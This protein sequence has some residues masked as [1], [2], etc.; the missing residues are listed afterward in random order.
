MG[1]PGAWKICRKTETIC[2]SDPHLF[3]RDECV[4]YGYQTE[5]NI[6][7]YAGGGGGNARS[8]S[9]SCKTSERIHT[10]NELL[11]NRPKVGGPYPVYND[12]EEVGTNLGGQ[13]RS[14]MDDSLNFLYNDDIAKFDNITI[15]NIIENN[16]LGSGGGEPCGHNYDDTTNR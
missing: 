1:V 8:G 13:S 10:L 12:K 2:S 4:K 15:S 7:Y 9:D 3:C 11:D 6:Y 5:S 14:N 16:L